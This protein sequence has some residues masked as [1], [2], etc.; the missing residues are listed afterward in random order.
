MTQPNTLYSI[1]IPVYNTTSVLATLAARVD[2][3]FAELPT[4]DYE[5]IF[6]DDSSPN[7]ET[8]P[9]IQ[10]LARDYPK[11]KAIQLT[12][13][14][15]QHAAT[16]CGLT[17]ARGDYVI[18]MDDDLEHLPESIPDLMAEQHHDVVIAQFE[19]PTHRLYRRLLSGLKNFLL[20]WLIGKPK[21]L[22]L[23]SLRLMKAVVARNL[24]AIATTP[25]AM[26]PSLIFFIT[27]DVVG[28]DCKHG[29]RNQAASGYTLGKILRVSRDLLFNDSVILLNFIGSLG[30][31][32]SLASL[33]TGVYF[34]AKTL[35]S[36]VGV[37]GWASTI[38][39][40]LFIGGLVLFSL[41]VM[42]QYILRIVSGVER[43]PMFLIRHILPAE[44][45]REVPS[46]WPKKD[47]A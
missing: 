38:V 9:A 28:V 20:V 37:A 45:V 15:G 13:N 23:S 32:I 35:A 17:H 26:I 6:V 11:I 47:S 16:I 4:A 10:A 46:E 21:G 39:T 8:W 27:K 30:L 40:L 25:H 3:V 1:V 22:R 5:I 12:R 33:C 36:G 44:G 34:V 31:G 24:V 42:G 19:Q 7:P 18:N 14:F 41:G 2:K 43:K 29:L